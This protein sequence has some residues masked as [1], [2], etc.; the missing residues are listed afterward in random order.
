MKWELDLVRNGGAGSEL[1]FSAKVKKMERYHPSVLPNRMVSIVVNQ[2][3]T[4]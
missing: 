3:D 1:D 4:R 2:L